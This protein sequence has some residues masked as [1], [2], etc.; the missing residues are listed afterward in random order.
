MPSFFLRKWPQD[1]KE[2]QEYVDPIFAEI[3]VQYDFMTRVLSF[4]QEQ[5]WKRRAVSLITN[6]GSQKRLLDLATGTGDFPL[7]LR[8]A[9][10]DAWI[11]G[12]DRNP[13]MLAIATQKC[14]RLRKAQFILGDLMQ[15]PL[16]DGLFDVVTMGYGLRYVVDIRK[17]LREVF[18]LLRSGGIFIC[19]DFGIP[20]SPLYRR[21][22]LG[23]LL[24]LGS[25]WGFVLHGSVSTYWHIVES[26]KAYPGQVTVEKWLEEAGF[27]KIKLLEELGGIVT[28]FYS[29]RP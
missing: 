17:T 22:C 23:Y 21:F 13:K 4:G 25:I 26:L 27:R 16:K 3:A 15:I 18:R 5:R 11:I 8:E 24:L 6:T 14:N 28:V 20:K 12:L 19:L 10:F 7:H 9:G 1:V 29:T 2:R